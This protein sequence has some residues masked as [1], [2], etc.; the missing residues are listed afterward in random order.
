[1][2]S[3]CKLMETVRSRNKHIYRPENWLVETFRKC[4]SC[5]STPW[6]AKLKKMDLKFVSS[7]QLILQMYAFLL[8]HPNAKKVL[9]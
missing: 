7:A 4:P 3:L 1:M 9:L 2:R 8:Q 5:A 6:L